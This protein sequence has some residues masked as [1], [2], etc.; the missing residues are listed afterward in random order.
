MRKERILA[1]ALAVLALAA[2]AACSSVSN[3]YVIDGFDKSDRTKTYRMHVV[4]QPLPAGDKKAGELWGLVA[5]R[6]VNHHRDFIAKKRT[7]A[8]NPVTGRCEGGMEA[9]LHMKPTLERVG[10]DVEATVTAALFRCPGGA[11]LWSAEAAGTWSI[12]DDELKA[13]TDRYA[14]ELGESVRPWVPAS[15]RILRELLDTLPK[16]KL[17]KDDDVM[18]KI[19]LEE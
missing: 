6:W 16:P 9:V 8:L 14:K 10:D 11:K 3:V 12:H 7:A 2:T 15:F 4:T 1:R 19:E 17:V 18:E 13:T 5:Q